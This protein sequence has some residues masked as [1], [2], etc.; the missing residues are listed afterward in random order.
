MA[1]R[2]PRVVHLHEREARLFPRDD[3]VDAG[4]FSKILS[5]TRNLSAIELREGFSEIELRVLGLVGYLPLTKD[6]VLNLRP[7]FPV[8]NLWKMLE[9]ADENYE[10][11]LPVLRGYGPAP[12]LPPHQFL[13]RAFCYFLS[14]ILSLGICRDYVATDFQG[15]YRPR[16]DFGRTASR[17]L[18]RG[19]E[20][21]VVGREFCFSRELRVNQLLKSACIEFARILPSSANWLK[22]RD[23]V[24]DALNTLEDLP[25]ATVRPGDEFLSLSLPILLR[26]SY[27]GALRVYSIYRGRSGLGFS[28]EAAGND[29]PS[30][31]FKLDDIFERFA[32]NVLRDG[33]ANVGISV[34]DGNK[35]EI[36]VPLFLD[37][38]RFPIKP[39][40]VIRHGEVVAAIAEMKYKRKLSEAD[41]YQV[42]SH[43]VAS[44]A[45]VGIWIHPKA[46]GEQ[47]GLQYVGKLADGQEFYQY[48]LD[49]SG[50]LDASRS[51]MVSDLL[52]LVGT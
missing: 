3:L 12:T 34:M 8:L 30:F 44:G 20:I 26:E 27:S 13:A 36:Q 35:P 2:A 31:L 25:E 41:R 9:L 39:D 1:D 4:G 17:L 37:N 50:D 23:L 42:I 5:D 21:G 10:R 19:D 11:I 16:V 52:P 24:M 22:E 49:I 28:Y 32:R 14:Q 47:A 46:E 51:G 18:S 48:R 29:M 33:L 15:Y 6:V 43:V 40:A 7:K 45:R 38:G